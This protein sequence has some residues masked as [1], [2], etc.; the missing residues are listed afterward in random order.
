MVLQISPR[1]LE[2]N[3]RHEEKSK[4]RIKVGG[5]YRD[6]YDQFAYFQPSGDVLVDVHGYRIPLKSSDYGFPNSRTVRVDRRGR[7]TGFS[8]GAEE[9]YATLF[10]RE[11]V[12][13]NDALET[14]ARAVNHSIEYDVSTVESGDFRET[15]KV[16]IRDSGYKPRGDETVKGICSDAGELI[17]TLFGLA[18]RD[19]TLR[20]VEV[21]STNE[22]GPHD[23]TVVFDTQT[24]NWAV[25]NSKSPLKPYNLVPRE[26]LEDLGHP[27]TR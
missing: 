24:G 26:R 11:E 16:A 27:F 21:A 7:V 4:V 8:P 10:E 20:Y 18:L 22:I 25:V 5:E 12:S 2:A 1:E 19:S 9:A 14:I 13:L 15:E 6:T 17:R 3:V 23:T